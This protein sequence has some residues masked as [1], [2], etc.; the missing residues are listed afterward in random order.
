MPV[1]S[2]PP[3]VT[4]AS[5]AHAHLKSPG[6]PRAATT[7]PS[8]A[9]W[10]RCRRSRKRVPGISSGEGKRAGR[11]GGARPVMALG[12]GFLSGIPRSTPTF[13]KADALVVLVD[14]PLGLGAPGTQELPTPMHLVTLERPYPLISVLEYELP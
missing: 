12:K 10:I 8:S 2:N 3:V 4:A 5:S 6:F 9:F 7:V 14:A 11:H 1:K 13:Q